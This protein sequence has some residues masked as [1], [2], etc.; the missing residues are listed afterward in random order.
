LT[1]EDVST[2]RGTKKIKDCVSLVFVKMQLEAMMNQCVLLDLMIFMK[3]CLRWRI[4]KEFENG[5]DEEH[6]KI[7]SSFSFFQGQLR[8]ATNKVK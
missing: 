8:D 7:I 5:V 2:V 6:D 4:C 3:K 1:N